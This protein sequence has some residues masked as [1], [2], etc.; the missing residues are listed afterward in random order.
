MGCVTEKQREGFPSDL[1]LE[2]D[3]V[4][5]RVCF[6]NISRAKSIKGSEWD[7]PAAVEAELNLR[8]CWRTNPGCRFG[9]ALLQILL[10]TYVDVLGAGGAHLRLHTKTQ[11]MQC[12]ISNPK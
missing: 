1:A 5:A 12:F 10:R 8:S 11:P 2:R 3:A 7:T 9:P 6:A 4:K